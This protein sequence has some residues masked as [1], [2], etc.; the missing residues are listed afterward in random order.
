MATLYKR[1]NARQQQILRV[2]E[3]AVR[4]ASSAHPEEH[5]ISPR[6]ARSIAKRAAGTLTALWQ[7]VL[8]TPLVSS[9]GSDR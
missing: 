3:G 5:P 1:A 9:D 6:M 2:V 7:D 4:N 8:A